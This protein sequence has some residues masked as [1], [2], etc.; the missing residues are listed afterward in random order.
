MDVAT[1]GRNKRPGTV[2]I[3]GT[4]AVSTIKTVK[5]KLVIMFDTKFATDVDADKRSPYL[6]EKRNRDVTHQ[7]TVNICNKL[8]SFKV[9]AECNEISEMVKKC[10]QQGR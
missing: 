5:T 1:I 9:T 3:I 6:K 2:S 10:I 7:K 4:A 8:S